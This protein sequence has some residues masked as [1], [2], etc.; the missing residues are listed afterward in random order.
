MFASAENL[1]ASHSSCLVIL[2]LQQVDRLRGLAVK[3]Y[4]VHMRM[5]L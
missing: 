4:T 2:T 5:S 3:Q 1:T